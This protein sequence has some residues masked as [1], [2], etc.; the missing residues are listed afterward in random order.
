MEARLFL[1]HVAATGIAILVV[2]VVTALVAFTV[3][4]DSSA[5]THGGSPQISQR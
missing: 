1:Q 5:S 2:A 4:S 3:H